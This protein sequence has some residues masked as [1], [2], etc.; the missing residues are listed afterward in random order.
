MGHF[1]I[2][3]YAPPLAHDDNG[4]VFRVVV[5]A[6]C[7][8]TLGELNSAIKTAMK[9]ALAGSSLE[10]W[11]R[12][13]SGLLYSNT[14]TEWT[15]ASPSL[16]Q[17]ATFERDWGLS[18][19]QGSVLK[20]RATLEL[21]PGFQFGT[22]PVLILDVI[23]RSADAGYSERRLSL[24]LT[25]LHKFLHVLGRAAV[26]EIASLIFPMLC[27]EGMPAIVGP[28]YEINFGDRS[29]ETTVAL[30]SSF[31]RPADAVSNPWAE[32]NTPEGSDPRDIAARDAAIRQGLEKLLRSN[33]YDG[34]EDEIAKLPGPAPNASSE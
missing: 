31:E 3:Q 27:A 18:T 32:I 30:P 23:E 16:G 11:G 5:A 34:I 13:A 10:R 1:K 9:E 14:A 4:T 21:P 15:R 6:D 24:S 26:D 29:L 12:S 2:R 17:V 19:T 33:E 20:G 8:R 7:E 22:R 28:N 25:E